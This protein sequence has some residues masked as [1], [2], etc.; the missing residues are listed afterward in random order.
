MNCEV[1]HRGHDPNR[2][3]P[4]GCAGGR[5]DGH[6][7]LRNSFFFTS[8]LTIFRNHH[9]LNHLTKEPG[10]TISVDFSEF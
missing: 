7:V 6:R 1:H 3:G 4:N 2:V 9:P 5:G 10:F 8:I